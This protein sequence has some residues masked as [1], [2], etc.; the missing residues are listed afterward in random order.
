MLRRQKDTRPTTVALIP[1][2]RMPDPM[3]LPG[4]TREEFSRRLSRPL[5]DLASRTGS[6]ASPGLQEAS[7]RV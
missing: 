3:E 4:V 5:A 1:C 7:G 2:W 6:H